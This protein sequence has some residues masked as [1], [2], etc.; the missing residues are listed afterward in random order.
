MTSGHLPAFSSAESVPFETEYDAMQAAL[1]SFAL[2]R[3]FGDVLPYGDVS[4]GPK[5]SFEGG[6]FL[7]SRS[8]ASRLASLKTYLR[9]NPHVSARIVGYGDDTQ[10]AA[11]EADLAESRAWAVVRALVVDVSLKN[12]IG[13]AGSG[14][15]TYARAA[16]IIF[17]MGSDAPQSS[18]PRRLTSGSGG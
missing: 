1:P 17:V 9:A 10:T 5:V 18:Q 2:Q 14:S 11:A 8:E 13:V 3:G 15:G 6:S 12:A 4:V 7:L 16:E